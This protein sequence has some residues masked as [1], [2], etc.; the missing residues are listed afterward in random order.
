MNL[1]WRGAITDKGFQV[2][3]HLPELRRFE[4]CWQQHIADAG[5]SNLAFCPH[6]EIVNLLGTP[7]GDGTIAALR[8]KSKTTTI[9][10]RS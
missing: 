8:G 9:P 10:Q 3:K 5:V 2:L 4:L 1:I 6:L 7:S